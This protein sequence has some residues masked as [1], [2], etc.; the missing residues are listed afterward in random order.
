M[1]SCILFFLLIECFSEMIILFSFDY[2]LDQ[3]KFDECMFLSWVLN[4][5]WVNEE[6]IGMG[7]NKFNNRFLD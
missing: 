2:V 1:R 4:F 5:L 7:K 6:Q 3:A